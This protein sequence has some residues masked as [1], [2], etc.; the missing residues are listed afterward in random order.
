MNL[1]MLIQ[2]KNTNYYTFQKDSRDVY[3]LTESQSSPE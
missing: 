2:L 1:F 3:H